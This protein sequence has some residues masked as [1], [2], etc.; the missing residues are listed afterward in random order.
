MMSMG[1][2]T[3]VTGGL[4]AHWFSSLGLMPGLQTNQGSV[5]MTWAPTHPDQWM[6]CHPVSSGP[7]TSTEAVVSL[8]HTP[9][10]LAALW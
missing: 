10:T 3:G 7:S 1:T 5:G 8:L 2:L 6:R 9:A 4:I